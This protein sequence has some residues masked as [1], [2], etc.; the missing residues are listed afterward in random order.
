MSTATTDDGRNPASGT[1]QGL[2]DFLSWAPE[3]NYMNSTTASGLRTGVKKVL[4]GEADLDQIDIRHA[5]IDDIVLRFR[6]RAHGKI[7]DQSVDAYEIRFRSSVEM[8]VK[9]LNHEKDWI[10]TP[11]RTRKPASSG[12]AVKRQM[13]SDVQMSEPDAPEL[14]PS[15]PGVITYPFP[16]R[17]GF[18][19]KITLPEN[20]TR[21]EAERI[22]AFIKTLA[23][24][25]EVYEH[26]PRAISGVVM[27]DNE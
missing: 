26:S 9:W 3:R 19:G 10:P 23:V 20:L 5:D 14:A 24:E 7:K 1:A 13:T 8:Y 21:R 15:G 11:S 12:G 4:E 6:N 2:M 22:A 27:D 17:A 25:D 18:Q 16:I